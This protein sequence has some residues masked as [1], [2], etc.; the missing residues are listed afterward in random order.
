VTRTFEQAPSQRSSTAWSVVAA[1]L[2]TFACT[3]VTAWL[4]RELFAAELHGIDSFAA[5]VAIGL[6]SGSAVWWRAVTLLG[7]SYVLWPLVLV[8]AIALRAGGRRGEALLLAEAMGGALVL[9]LALKLALRRARPP[10]LWGDPLP[11]TYSFP[12]GHALFTATLCLVLAWIA[13]R[14]L[15]IGF[16]ILVWVAAIVV[17]LAVGASRVGLGMHYATDVLGGH[18]TALL[19]L[20]ALRIARRRSSARSPGTVRA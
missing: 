11:S 3:V 13:T 15:P 20:V 8:I 19:W 12:S 6:G 4:A 9:E 16:S 5:A 18:A 1:A 14:R 10:A 17:P 2:V 7:T